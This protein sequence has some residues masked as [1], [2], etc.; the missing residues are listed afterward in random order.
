MKTKKEFNKTEFPVVVLLLEN[1]EN[2]LDKDLV[3]E[4]VM[5]I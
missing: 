4:Q 1:P 5:L 3:F 2:G